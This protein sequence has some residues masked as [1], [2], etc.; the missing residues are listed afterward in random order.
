MN[1]HDVQVLKINNISIPLNQIYKSIHQSVLFDKHIER[2]KNYFNKKYNIGLSIM[3]INE[4]LNLI[5]NV[6]YTDD[7]AQYNWDSYKKNLKLN[8]FHH[9]LWLKT[10]DVFVNME[11]QI[12]PHP[13]ETKIIE[14]ILGDPRSVNLFSCIVG[15]RV[16]NYTA[17]IYN[18]KSNIKIL[19]GFDF[20]S[21]F[22]NDISYNTYINLMVDFQNLANILDPFMFYFEKYN[23]INDS[24]E[25]ENMLK[26]DSFNNL[27]FNNY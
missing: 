19:I 17:I 18:E 9:P 16:K 6:F 10:M 11:K 3:A 26:N 13:L 8:I 25:L 24:F 27:Y 7:W 2:V 1:S 23:T 14:G 12:K 4:N 5:N 21:G 15:K 22:L 20:N